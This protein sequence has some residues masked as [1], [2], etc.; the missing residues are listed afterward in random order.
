MKALAY[1]GLLRHGKNETLSDDLQK[2]LSI[3]RWMC[4]REC[5]SGL[6]LPGPEADH[7]SARPTIIKMRGGVTPVRL[8]F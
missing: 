5:F 4:T 6:K 2:D 7:P 1:W 3:S 8:N